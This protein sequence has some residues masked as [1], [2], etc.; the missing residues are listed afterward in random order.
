V[1][2]HSLVHEGFVFRLLGSLEDEG[3][4]GGGVPGFVGLHGLKVARV[5]HDDGVLFELF[6]LVHVFQ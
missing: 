2:G 5:C 3:G 6:E 4:I 1:L